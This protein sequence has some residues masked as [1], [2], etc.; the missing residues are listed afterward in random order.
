LNIKEGIVT[1]AGHDLKPYDTLERV[2]TMLGNKLVEYQG[3]H[4]CYGYDFSQDYDIFQV[5]DRIILEKEEFHIKLLFDKK[6]EYLRIYSLSTNDYPDPH[7][8]SRVLSNLLET[9]INEVHSEMF[10]GLKP[11]SNGKITV[12][13]KYF[14]KDLNG[15]L[16][17]EINY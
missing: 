1:I 17:I 5:N 16:H 7:M 8:Y 9:E 13:S 6:N 2:K 3:W 15:F 12:E 10:F 14:A 4:G 11:Y